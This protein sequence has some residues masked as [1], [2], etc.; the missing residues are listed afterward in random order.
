MQR[1]TVTT[2][3]GKVNCKVAYI[4]VNS[5]VYFTKIGGIQSSINAAEDIV[6]KISETE[7]LDFNRFVWVDVQTTQFCSEF[8]VDKL[9]FFAQV[10]TPLV[11]NWEPTELPADVS[12]ALFDHEA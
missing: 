6:G 11:S 3:A 7:E 10:E 12:I 4:V 5:T 8:S 1:K 2:G 9:V